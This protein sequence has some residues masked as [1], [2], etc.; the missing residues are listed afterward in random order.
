VEI[1]KA[2]DRFATRLRLREKEQANVEAYL[3]EFSTG[4]D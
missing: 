2:A 4:V 1:H 3:R